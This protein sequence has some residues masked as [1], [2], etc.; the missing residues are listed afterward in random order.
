MD[1]TFAARSPF[2]RQ[3]RPP[4]RRRRA[5]DGASFAP[6]AKLRGLATSLL[7]GLSARPRLRLALICL[8]VAVPLLGG[9]WMWFRHSSFVGAEQIRVSGAEG[10]EASAIEAALVEAAHGMSTLAPS[11]GALKAAVSRFPQVSEVRAIPSFPHGMKIDIVEQSPAAVLVVGGLRT[12]VA[13]NG[14]VLGPSLASSALPVVSDDVVP[15]VG[16]RLGNPLLLEAVAVLGAAPSEFS[17]LVGRAYVGPRGL[18]VAMKN[19]LLVYFGDAARPHAKWDSLVAVL[20]D[21]SSAGA[22]Y[23]DVRLPGRPAAGFGDAAAAEK[24]IVTGASGKA[25]GESTVSALAAGLK[26]DS[27]QPVTTPAETEAGHESEAAS[28]G[29]E[30]SSEAS[31][32]EE[33]GSAPTGGEAATTP[34]G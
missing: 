15:G 33:A 17:G 26:A 25:S 3:G 27:P 8:A 14:V 23:I 1:R 16:A 12:A 20:G 32:S 4:A 31:A 13:A 34:G 29:G 30:S 21:P 10:P 18:T 7:D 9:G 11:A 2:A 22:S 6:A 19:G 5:G 28:G 24:Q